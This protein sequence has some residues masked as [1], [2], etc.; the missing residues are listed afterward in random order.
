ME[1]DIHFSQCAPMEQYA[2]LNMVLTPGQRY[3]VHQNIASV[4]W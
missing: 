2:V 4:Y 3:A 1:D